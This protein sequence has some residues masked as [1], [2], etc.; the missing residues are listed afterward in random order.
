MRLAEGPV[1]RPAAAAR[2]RPDAAESC[3]SADAD[4]AAEPPSTAEHSTATSRARSACW[5]TRR[6]SGAVGHEHTEEQVELGAVSKLQAAGGAAEISATSIADFPSG[7]DSVSRSA[8]TA[9]PLTVDALSAEVSAL[10]ALGDDLSNEKTLPANVEELFCT[11]ANVSA[12]AASSD[13][14]NDASI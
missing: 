11:G 8:P 7:V 1:R 5:R 10:H 6:C 4:N 3:P 12:P 9:F 13:A 2:D 14:E